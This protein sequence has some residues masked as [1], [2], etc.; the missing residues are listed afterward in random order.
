MNRAIPALLVALGT[1]MPPAYA[2]QTDS[3]LNDTQLRGRQMFSQSCGVCHLPPTLNAKTYGPML[4]KTTAA[5]NDAAM[6]VI[7]EHGTE[8]MPAFK[9]YLQG[10]DIDAIIAYVRTLPV[11]AP[12]SASASTGDMQ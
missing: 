3:T 8:R 10:A 2:Q 1:A 4:N 7:I 5:G 12:S 11:Q 9:H 6:R